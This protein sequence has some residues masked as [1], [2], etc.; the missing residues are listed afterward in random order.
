MTV[1][2]KIEEQQN[3]CKGSMAYYVGEYI[4]EWEEVQL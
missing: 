4:T 2:E 3:D 1:F